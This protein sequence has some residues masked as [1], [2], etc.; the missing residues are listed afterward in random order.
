MKTYSPSKLKSYAKFSKRLGWVFLMFKLFETLV[1]FLKIVV[2]PKFQSGIIRGDWRAWVEVPTY[3]TG[4]L[5]E[6]W[7]YWFLLLG[8]SV[9]LTVLSEIHLPQRRNDIAKVSEHHQ[10]ANVLQTIKLLERM[11]IVGVVATLF[12]S[13]PSI[14]QL[15]E[16]AFSLRLSSEASWGIWIGSSISLLFLECGILYLGFRG[17]AQVLRIMM[18]IEAR[19]L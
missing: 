18:E 10:A 5:F 16:T 9:G 19:I 4:I 11:A 3:L 6:G 8:L 12:V 2:D 7:V 17:S 14:L 13:V 1:E 15:R